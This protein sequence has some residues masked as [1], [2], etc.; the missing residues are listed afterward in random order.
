MD[1]TPG[2]VGS[3]CMNVQFYQLAVG[4]AFEF[5]GKRYRKTAMSMAADERDWGNVFEGWTK[6]IS[7]GPLLP[8]EVAAKWAPD[9]AMLRYWNLDGDAES[10]AEA[11]GQSDVCENPS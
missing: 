5:R 10:K 1:G 8:P 11:G 7:D 2:L 4:A 6:V 3:A 9:P